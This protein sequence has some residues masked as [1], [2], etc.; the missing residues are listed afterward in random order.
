MN[1]FPTSLLLRAEE[2]SVPS[3]AERD[4]QC[5]RSGWRKKYGMERENGKMEET[6]RECIPIEAEGRELRKWMNGRTKK[7]PLDLV[8]GSHLPKPMSV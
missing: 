6:T 2:L 3:E 4:P 5:L 1:C 7:C 8:G